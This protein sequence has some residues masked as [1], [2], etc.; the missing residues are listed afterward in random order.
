M[1]RKKLD[2][3]V[4]LNDLVR[5]F[6]LDYMVVIAP[7]SKSEKLGRVDPR[8]KIIYIY[9]D[10]PKLAYKILLHEI[11]EIMLKPLLNKYIRLINVLI[12]YIQNELYI[13]KERILDEFTE[14]FKL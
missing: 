2:L 14:L 11:L 3:E 13:E 8:N 12:D 6:G 10:D 7:R 9:T 1:D 4:E 5:R